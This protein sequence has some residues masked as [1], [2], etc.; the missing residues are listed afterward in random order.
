M[1]LLLQGGAS[2]LRGNHSS[3]ELILTCKVLLFQ[4]PRVTALWRLLS[5]SLG[6]SKWDKIDRMK[7]EMSIIRSVLVTLWVQLRSQYFLAKVSS[8]SLFHVYRILI[9][10]LCV[11]GLAPIS[12]GTEL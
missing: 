6:Q 1:I 4:E 12:T 7:A 11:R 9:Q 10:I 8:K 2:C 5:L 3:L